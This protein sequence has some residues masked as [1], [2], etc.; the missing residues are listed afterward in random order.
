M[1]ADSTEEE[2]VVAVLTRVR[3]KPVAMGMRTSLQIQQQYSLPHGTS[4]G[5]DMYQIEK[6]RQQELTLYREILTLSDEQV[7]ALAPD[8]REQVCKLLFVSLAL[9][10]RRMWSTLTPASK[11]YQPG[12]CWKYF[13][14]RL[15][16]PLPL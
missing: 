7:E 12:W 15:A 11:H 9:L 1:I 2:R 4:E 8:E 6:L 10:S 14:G 3:M 16:M 5:A 13:V